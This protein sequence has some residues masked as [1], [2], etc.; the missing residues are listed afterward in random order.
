MT[1]KNIK[2]GLD[3]I[4]LKG[5]QEERA[6]REA[7]AF[8]EKASKLIPEAR[9]ETRKIVCEAASQL[10]FFFQTPAFFGMNIKKYLYEHGAGVEYYTTREDLRVMAKELGIDVRELALFN[11]LEETIVYTLGI[12]SC[13]SIGIE[14]SRTGNGNMI[15]RNLDFFGRGI[16]DR[17]AVVKI[18]FPFGKREIPYIVLG[19]LP[20]Y[21]GVSHTGMNQEGLSVSLNYMFAGK[22]D[23]RGKPVPLILEE[24]LLKARTVNE[25]ENIL[26]DNKTANHWGFLFADSKEIVAIEKNNSLQ[27]NVKTLPRDGY[28]VLTNHSLYDVPENLPWFLREIIKASKKR[29]EIVERELEKRARITNEELIKILGYGFK[30]GKAPEFLNPAEWDKS[31]CSYFTLVSVIMYPEKRAAHI[32]VG[33]P[34]IK[35][36]GYYIDFDGYHPEI[37]L[38]GKI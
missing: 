24:I 32:F 34:A 3:L 22:Q 17:N 26:R 25:A 18:H 33:S 27:D 21:L 11:L 2:P 16:L 12:P 8:K 36:K 28:L 1:I 20:C 31:V 5:S 29:K 37:N 13:T 14:K 30:P 38:Q 9:R 23:R 7:R 10:P 4:V 6:W 15:G 19:D 35:E